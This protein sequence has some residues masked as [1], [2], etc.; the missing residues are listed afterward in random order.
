VE[1]LRD[2][3]PADRSTAELSDDQD[4]RS[5]IGA[6]LGATPVDEQ[7]LRRAVWMYVSA[8]RHG[9]TAPGHVIMALTELVD[10]SGIDPA[11]V[12]QA[13]MRSVILWCVEAYFGHLSGDVVGR[14]GDA[15][16]DSPT[17]VSNR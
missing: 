13:T 4:P 17:Y 7:T 5:A 1:Q 14:S 6:A 11:T 16:S 8:E 15:L 10:A 2:D 9:G 3:V 12:R